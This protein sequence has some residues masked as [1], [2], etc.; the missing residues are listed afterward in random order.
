MKKITFLVG[1]LLLST[2]IMAQNCNIHGKM[3]TKECQGKKV[4]LYNL[5]TQQ[6]L[7]STV[8]REG[9]FN[10]SAEV[11]TPSVLFLR[12]ERLPEGNYYQAKLVGEGG[13]I[14]VNL[15]NDDLS[16]TPLN[17]L[18]REKMGKVQNAFAPYNKLYDS[19]KSNPKMSGEALE[20]LQKEMEIAIADIVN[21][22]RECYLETKDNLVGAMMME[23]LI[24]YD[25]S[26]NLESLH[27]L[28]DGA[29]PEVMEYYRIKE[30]ISMMEI[31]EQTA[32]GKKYQDLDLKDG[33][34]G[35][36]TKLSNV[37]DGKIA[38]VD[39]WASWCRPCRAEIPN[40]ANVYKKYGKEIVVISLNVWDKNDAR[41]KA[42]K[43]LKMD[44]VQL[45]DEEGDATKKYGIEGIPHIMLIGADGTILNRDLRGEDI[46]V[47][48]KKA[49][50]K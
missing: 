15:V 46:E 6:K 10:F 35:K 36:A 38:L 24:E 44:W 42:I 7:D 40:I 29:A 49:L 18:Y 12:T 8:V 19:Y 50:G 16:G 41:V 28:L 30:T 17:D 25:E 43:D 45:T 47:A 37:I 39:F 1:G 48:V 14:M 32:V 33:K 23:Q 34:T 31:Q 13:E 20:K 21:V 26:L 27:A 11:K 2:A 3:D 22:I 4:Y 5:S 9:S